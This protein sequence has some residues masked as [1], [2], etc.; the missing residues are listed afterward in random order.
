LPS[1]Q[2]LDNANGWEGQIDNLN[3]KD[4]VKVYFAAANNNPELTRILLEAGA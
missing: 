2:P 3:E 1:R 4:K